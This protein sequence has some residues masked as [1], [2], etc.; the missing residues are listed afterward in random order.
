MEFTLE[1]RDNDGLGGLIARPG[2]YDGE[3]V[4][5]TL[6][7]GTYPDRVE[8]NLVAVA[9]ALAFEAY[10]EDEIRL[11]L[12]VT[13]QVALAIG[14]FF[15]PRVVRVPN[16]DYHPRRLTEGPGRMTV[17][18][19]PEQSFG[20]QH[21]APKLGTFNI[22]LTDTFESPR[23]FA[24]KDTVVLPSNGRVLSPRPPGDSR[25]LLPEVAAALL[26]AGELGVKDIHL[27]D[28][29]H[30]SDDIHL[31]KVRRM[32]RAVNRELTWS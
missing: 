10:I 31:T 30:A 20:H 15:M 23:G 3:P 25:C 1:K 14:E 8:S 21:D 6:I 32:L 13:P 19:S 18:W 5:R 26:I 11:D 4:I 12:P 9:A 22:L 28:I 16:V 2:A 29:S 24:Y 27:T 17:S 7:V